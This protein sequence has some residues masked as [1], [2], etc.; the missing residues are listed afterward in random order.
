MKIPYNKIRSL[1]TAQLPG[2]ICDPILTFEFIANPSF[3][4]M[5]DISIWMSDPKWSETKRIASSLIKAVII[6][7]DERIA[8]GSLETIQD[9]AGETD[10]AFVG[11]L[12]N[13]WNTFVSL[14]RIAD[15]KKNQLLSALSS[16]TSGAKEPA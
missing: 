9:L 8:L 5:K 13:G 10:K 12:I 4:L 16:G 6:P 2:V 14:E 11:N 1:S 3:E 15:L 7:G